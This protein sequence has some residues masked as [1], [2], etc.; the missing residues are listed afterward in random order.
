MKK[1]LR[2]YMNDIENLAK[3]YMMIKKQ[4]AADYG[5][6]FTS[7]SDEQQAL[8]TGKMLADILGI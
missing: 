4:L 8:I 7:L 2:E 6:T 1:E 3:A 5:K